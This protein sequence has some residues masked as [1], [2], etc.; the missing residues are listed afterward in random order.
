MNLCS[1]SRSLPVCTCIHFRTGNH[2]AEVTLRRGWPVSLAMAERLRREEA[3]ATTG[4]RAR[5]GRCP[6][7]CPYA[8]RAPIDVDIGVAEGAAAAAY[9]T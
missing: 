1:A 3:V 4:L 9:L 6:A 7:T 8:R 2:V 5:R